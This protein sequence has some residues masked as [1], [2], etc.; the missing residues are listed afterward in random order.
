MFSLLK[1]GAQEK[2]FLSYSEAPQ[3]E[4]QRTVPFNVKSKIVYVT[5]EEAQANAFYHR[6][7]IVALVV[8]FLSGGLF[9]KLKESK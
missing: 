9:L 3:I 8:A 6:M 2:A 1:N 7:M 5:N 4:Q